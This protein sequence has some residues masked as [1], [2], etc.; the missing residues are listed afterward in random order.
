MRWSRKKERFTRDYYLT[1]R[2]KN[3]KLSV[4]Y[5]D[6]YK[7]FYFMTEDKDENTFNSLWEKKAYKTEEECKQAC[8]KWVDNK[9]KEVEA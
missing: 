9:I 6:I 8:V 5:S 2:Y 4:E 7:Y 3:Y 1:A